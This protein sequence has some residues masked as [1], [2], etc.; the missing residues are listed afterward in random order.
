MDY[1]TREK[2]TSCLPE[3]LTRTNAQGEVYQRQGV[4]DRQR[5]EMLS[6]FILKNSGDAQSL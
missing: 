1:E 3:P 6:G 4:V 5:S 2:D